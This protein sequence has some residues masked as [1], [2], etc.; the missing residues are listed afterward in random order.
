MS[1][2]FYEVD[3]DQFEE[4]FQGRLSD[5]RIYVEGNSR[6]ETTRRILN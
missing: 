5:E 2:D 6:E 3:D 4:E 1:L